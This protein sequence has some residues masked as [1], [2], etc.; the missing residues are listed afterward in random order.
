MQ[1]FGAWLRINPFGGCT[2]DAGWTIFSITCQIFVLSSV[3]EFGKGQDGSG[4]RYPKQNG[5]FI[6]VPSLRRILTVGIFALT[7]LA[8]AACAGGQSPAPDSDIETASHRIVLPALS[9]A[10]QARIQQQ[11]KP[12]REPMQT[13]LG[14]DLEAGEAAVPLS[15]LAWQT[16]GDQETATI[17][18]SSRGAL[19]LRLG[20]NLQN[21]GCPLSFRFSGSDGGTDESFT[22][23]TVAGAEALWWSPVTQGETA[24]IHFSRPSGA[25]LTSC[26]LLIPQISHLF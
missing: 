12:D 4:I 10:E 25:E 17:A 8:L 13:G 15:E 20:L 18:V 6:V 9:E 1:K 24:F 23:A 11:S 26:E 2:F 7:G 16:V 22:A 19:G 21:D 3:E 5:G 14:R